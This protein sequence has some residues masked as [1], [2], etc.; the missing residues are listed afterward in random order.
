M[1]KKQ[2]RGGSLALFTVLA[3]W[4][5]RQREGDRRDGSPPK[6]RKERR[7]T[8]W[9]KQFGSTSDQRPVLTLRHEKEFKTPSHRQQPG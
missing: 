4:L 7:H 3:R 8:R 2:G 5:L 6:K 1:E 9:A